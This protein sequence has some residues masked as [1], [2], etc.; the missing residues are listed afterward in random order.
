MPLTL[1]T[2]SSH[3]EGGNRDWSI[4]TNRFTGENGQ[5][6]AI[7]CV[8]LEWTKTADGKTNMTPVPGSEFELKADWFFWRW[9]FVRPVHEGLLDAWASI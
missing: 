9:A 8:R 4:N 2:S 3:E 1:R 6:T 5:V 7:E